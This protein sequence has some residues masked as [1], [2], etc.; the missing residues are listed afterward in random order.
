MRGLEGRNLAAARGISFPLFS[1]PSLSS[2]KTNPPCLFEV[3]NEEIETQGGWAGSSWLPGLLQQHNLSLT[4]CPPEVLV[5]MG[6]ATTS[7]LRP[8]IPGM[9]VEPGQGSRTLDT[10]TEKLLPPKSQSPGRC[11]GFVWAHLLSPLSLATSH[12]LCRDAEHSSWPCRM[13]SSCT[14]P[15]RN[16]R[17]REHRLTAKSNGL[18][19][20]LSLCCLGPAEE[21]GIGDTPNLEDEAAA[22]HVTQGQWPESPRS[23]GGRGQRWEHSVGCTLK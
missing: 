13:H 10:P 8:L 1:I 21:A 2:Y 12:G 16:A 18:F 9:L 17:Y 6:R 7:H 19:S 11:V 5:R 3:P 15:E 22:G 20:A 14:F 23:R 4:P